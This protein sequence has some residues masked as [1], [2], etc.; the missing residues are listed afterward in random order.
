M[1][2]LCC[3]LINTI[4]RNCRVRN[5]QHIPIT[6]IFFTNKKLFKLTLINKRLAEAKTDLNIAECQ[7]GLN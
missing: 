2:I 7:P 5:K 1:V 6:E 4:A 3:T